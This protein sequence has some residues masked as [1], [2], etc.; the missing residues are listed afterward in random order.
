[1]IS[2][3]CCARSPR[4]FVLFLCL[5]APVTARAQPVAPQR[6][7]T[8]QAL[9]EQATSEM[10]AGRYER[11]CPRLEEVVR[12]A[13]DA[14]GAKLTLGECYEGWGKLASAWSQYVLVEGEATKVGDLDRQ[15][16][17]AGKSAALKPK[18]ATLTIE[19]P[20]SVR[21]V[22][23]LTITRDG[24]PVRE[25]QWS[26]PLPLDVGRHE[27][28]VSGRGYKTSKQQI[29]IAADGHRV[30]VPVPP[31][32]SMTSAGSNPERPWQRPAAIVAIGLGGAGLAVGAVLGG[33]AIARN[34]ESNDGHCS[35]QDRCDPAGL[36]LRRQAVGLG[37]GSTV[38]LV[39]GGLL[40]AGGAVLFVTAP[41]QAQRDGR[42]QSR[43]ARWRAE[44]ALLPGSVAV[45]GVW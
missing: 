25:A 1:M 8:V 29:E 16:K 33:L 23:G 31:L 18:L 20:A 37:N 2:P 4:A 43:G 35:A 44:I 32:E 12:L 21:S 11:A 6:E 34:Q 36:D 14:L 41:S 24:L 27:I 7:T 42:A 17:A 13:P 22:P 45:Q 15:M 10:D 28:V 9:Y 40:A 19:V 39:T 3:A 30:A 5:L 26:V 38:A